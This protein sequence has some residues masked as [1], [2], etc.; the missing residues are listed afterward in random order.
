VSIQAAATLGCL[1]F[2]AGC[3]VM[4][5]RA[6]RWSRREIRRQRAQ[7]GFFVDAHGVVRMRQ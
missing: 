1:L 5:V 7:R 2:I 6:D 4:S 3:I